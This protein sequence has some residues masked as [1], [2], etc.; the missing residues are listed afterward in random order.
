MKGPEGRRT[1]VPVHG[2]RT[3]P[4]G[5]LDGIIEDAGLTVEQFLDLLRRRGS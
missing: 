1:T 2:N 5:T 4:L 3:L